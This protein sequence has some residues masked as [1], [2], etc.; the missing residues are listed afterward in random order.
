MQA[1]SNTYASP[2][3]N[4]DFAAYKAK[5]SAPGV[6]DKFQVNRVGPLCPQPRARYLWNDH[7]EPGPLAAPLCQAEYS[8]ISYPTYVANELAEIKATHDSLVAHTREQPACA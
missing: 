1:L 6:V 3:P 2:P 8:S 7:S 4:I 5:I